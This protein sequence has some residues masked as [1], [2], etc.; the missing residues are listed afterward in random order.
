MYRILISD[1]LGEEG[2]ARLAEEPDITFDVKTD[3]DKDALLAAMPDY[4]ALIVRSGTHVDADVLDAATRLKVVGRAGVGVDNIDLEAATARGVLV[5]NTPGANSVA[6]AEH[7]LALMLAWSRHVAPAHVSVAA[8]KWQRSQFVGMELRGKTLGIVGLGRVGRLVAERAAA[9][10]MTLLGYDPVVNEEA[11][12]QFGVQ[13]TPLDT[14]LARADFVTLHAAVTPETRQMINAKFIGRMKDG[15]VLINVARG[16]LVD[17]AALAA[18]LKNGKLR[19]VAV[20]VYSSEPPGATHPLIGMDGVLHTPH[21][22]AS[23]LEAQRNVA[24][25]VVEQVISVLQGQEA[26]HAVNRIT[27]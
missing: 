6:T 9:F 3:L 17:E 12:A 27:H 13:W 11:A 10:G 15:A 7:T 14:L 2:L 23:T 22:G 1:K 21:L 26:A 25:Q 19:G 4:D 18:A 5:V 16:A 20:D 8:G 24:V